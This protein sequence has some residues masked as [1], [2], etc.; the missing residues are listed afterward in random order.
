MLRIKTHVDLSHQYRMFKN[1]RHVNV[2]V[3][4]KTAVIWILLS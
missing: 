3:D 2:S 4:P 1:W